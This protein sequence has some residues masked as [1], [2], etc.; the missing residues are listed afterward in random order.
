M[1]RL[2]VPVILLAALA[3]VV[4]CGKT[5]IDDTKTEDAIRQ[6]LESDLGKQVREV[7]CPSDVEVEPKSTFECSVTLASGKEETA[8]LR[9][10]NDDA[11]VAVVSL[12]PDG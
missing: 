1:S 7:D 6:N 8:R 11:D 3:L 4:G 9:I 10:I 5:V 12:Q 2:V